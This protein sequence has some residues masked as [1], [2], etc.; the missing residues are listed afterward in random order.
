MPSKFRPSVRHTAGSLKNDARWD[1][2]IFTVGF[3]DNFSFKIRNVFEISDV[4]G[5]FGDFSL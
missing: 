2:P 4:F 5:V 3:A 1:R